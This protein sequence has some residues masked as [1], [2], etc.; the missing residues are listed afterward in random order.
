[1]TSP[2]KQKEYMAKYNAT[3]T[4]LCVFVE[5]SVALALHEAAKAESLKR[6]AIGEDPISVPGL[7]RKIIA[8]YLAECASV[9]C[10]P[11]L[12]ADTEGRR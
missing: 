2:E 12:D 8:K 6:K 7:L 11:G 10:G 4:R 3:H 5:P 9:P 1:M